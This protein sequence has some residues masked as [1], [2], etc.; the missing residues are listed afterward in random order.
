MAKVLI[1]TASWSDRTLTGCGRFYP[2]QAKSPAERLRYY[3][4][5]FPLVEVDSPFYALPSPESSRL[6]AERTPS[7][8]TFDIKAFR[9]LTQH[10]TPLASLPRDLREGLR[11]P[12]R[13]APSRNLYWRDLPAEVNQELWRRFAE[14]LRPLEQ[15]GKLGLVLFQ[16]PPWFRPGGESEDYLVFCQEKLA[17]ARLAVEFRHGSWLDHQHLE[18]TLDFLEKN[19]L[20]YV[21]VDGPQGFETSLPPLAVA[22]AEVAV[23]RFHGRNRATWEKKGL[24]PAERFC[25]LYRQEELVEWL[26][27]IQALAGQ[28]EAVHL[29][30]NNCYEDYAIRNARDLAELL[31]VSQTHL[32][33][34]GAESP[35]LL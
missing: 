6:W 19:G 16:F 29:L 14:G 20:A 35:R 9:L 21:A 30:M 31:G 26:P 13:L 4:R 32:P 23:V 15:A 18:E 12:D 5:H 7:G 22:T 25:Y 8:F 17:G 11:S 33:G 10:P 3:A 24:T 1:G 2:T 34:M 28:S 27:R